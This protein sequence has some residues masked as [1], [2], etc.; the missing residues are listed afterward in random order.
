MPEGKYMNNKRVGESAITCRWNKK[1]KWK[2]NFR[3]T[4]FDVSLKNIAF[5]GLEVGK[6]SFF[7][8]SSNT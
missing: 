6:K 4:N 1:P 2:E 8:L 7:G 3:K 5:K